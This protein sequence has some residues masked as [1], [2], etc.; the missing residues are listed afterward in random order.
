MNAQMNSPRHRNRDGGKRGIWARSDARKYVVDF[1]PE[2]H[3]GRALGAAGGAA[4][5]ALDGVKGPH[6][7]DDA[8][9]FGTDGAIQ[10]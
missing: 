3:R 9:S 7:P 2:T 1:I 5:A 10:I 4:E 8:L 6:S